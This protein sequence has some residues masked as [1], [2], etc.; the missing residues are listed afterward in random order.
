MSLSRRVLHP[1][2]SSK[3]WI[4]CLSMRHFLFFLVLNIFSLH[5]NI[6]EIQTG[7][8]PPAPHIVL[9]DDFKS[10]FPNFPESSIEFL[11]PQIF[12][13]F[14]P[15]SARYLR[16]RCQEASSRSAE[17]ESDEIPDEEIPAEDS[18]N[19]P[20][21]TNSPEH[22][23]LC[24]RLRDLERAEEAYD[25]AQQ[26]A[27][28]E[29]VQQTLEGGA[30]DG[31]ARLDGAGNSGESSNN[32]KARRLL[33]E[34]R[35]LTEEV[36]DSPQNEE[37]INRWKERGWQAKVAF[38][39][40]TGERFT[41][42]I[43]INSEHFNSVVTMNI[44][45]SENTNYE[46]AYGLADFIEAQNICRHE[47]FSC[48]R[49]Y[50]SLRP[51]DS[52]DE[53]FFRGE[54]GDDDDSSLA[55]S[56]NS[57]N[58]SS[59]AQH[60]QTGQTSHQAPAWSMESVHIPSMEPISQHSFQSQMAHLMQH[61]L[62]PGANSTNPPPAGAA[63]QPDA[64][65][66]ALNSISDGIQQWAEEDEDLM[67]ESSEYED[68][69]EEWDRERIEKIKN[70]WR[71][72]A[73][74]YISQLP[75]P[76]EPKETDEPCSI[77]AQD[78]YRKGDEVQELPCGHVF[79]K[80]NIHKWLREESPYCPNCRRSIEEFYEAREIAKDFVEENVD[81]ALGTVLSQRM[82]FFDRL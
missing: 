45:H 51:L 36:S 15:V 10:K 66:E 20:D 58:T 52:D 49:L 30:D 38:R 26:R 4:L 25:A 28:S 12:R 43:E 67:S 23:A 64:F 44:E 74:K 31:A 19:I 9:T 55:D 32:D 47:D 78:G 79:L 17:S 16:K 73:E 18:T 50:D 80:E 42:S 77:S 24:D 81:L 41:S 34:F 13:I 65:A 22:C 59:S 6:L 70:A 75:A 57:T 69:D 46:T 71:A 33:E 60:G 53:V 35:A 5:S 1:A 68:V 3:S 8:Q 27:Q 76:R 7:T 29:Q 37:L 40:I 21:S 14:N 2:F 54:G 63:V 82:D 11:T 72:K 39:I 61:M 56:T 62:I 48:A